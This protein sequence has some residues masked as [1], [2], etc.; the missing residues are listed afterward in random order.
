MGCSISHPV[1]ALRRKGHGAG[2]RVIVAYLRGVVARR[3][4]ASSCVYSFLRWCVTL[5][6]CDITFCLM[7]VVA[8][9][10]VNYVECLV[11]REQNKKAF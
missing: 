1:L 10:Y 8:S 6:W 11:H 2:I 7:N 9:W 3:G 5:R 4:V